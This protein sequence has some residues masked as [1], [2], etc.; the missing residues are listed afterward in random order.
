MTYSQITYDSLSHLLTSI[1]I[2]VYSLS[3]FLKWVI[4]LSNY[5]IYHISSI[6]MND[7]YSV[8]VWMSL[9]TVTQIGGARGALKLVSIKVGALMLMTKRWMNE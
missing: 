1:S 9:L 5:Q 8:I 7:I 4:S 3:T 2:T 6:I